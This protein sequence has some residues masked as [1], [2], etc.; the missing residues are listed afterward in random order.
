MPEP[1]SLE[2]SHLS[3]VPVNPEA[4]P[5]CDHSTLRPFDSDAGPLPP[6]PPGQPPPLGLE[7][8]AD[9]F[10]AGPPA[11]PG[12][13]ILEVLGRGGMGVVYKARHLAL[14]RLVALKVILGGPHASAAEVVRFRREAEAVARL[15]NPHIVQIHEVGE[16]N[17]LPYF[18]LEYCSGGSLADKT[19]GT[20]LPAQQAAQLLQTL[21]R[22]VHAAHQG[23][24]IHRDLKPANILLQR[25][26]EIPN[27]KSEN[28]GGALV[29]DIGFRIS[30]FDP[31]ITDFGLAKRLDDS[32]GQTATGAIV[33]TP[34]Y[35][36]PEQAMG[37]REA[38]GAGVDV[39]ALGAV[40]YELL[41]GRPPFN[42]ETPL[43]TVRQV[44]EEE[45]VSPRLLQPKTPRDLETVCLKCLAKQPARRYATAEALADDLARFL[46]DEPIAARPVG[47]LERAW[48]WAKRRPLAAA[49]A[50]VSTAAVLTLLGVG[51]WYNARLREAVREEQA[52]TAHARRQQKL[53]ET[54]R[55][56]AEANLLDARRAVDQMLTEVAQ[57]QLARVPQMEPVR[58]ALLQKALA[59]YQRFLRQTGDD[60]GVRLE[61]GRA[62]RR[63]ADIY[64]LL[65]QRR[66]AEASYGQAL[67]LLGRLADNYAREPR[68]RFELAKTQRRHGVLLRTADRRTQA[69]I[70][71]RQ[72]RVVLE[73]LVDNHPDQPGYLTELATVHNNLGNLLKDEHQLAQAEKAYRMALAIQKKLVKQ[74]RAA[75]RYQADL[76]MTYNN[77]AI[78]LRYTRRLSEAGKKYR[79]AI[80]ILEGLVRDHPKEPDYRLG[81]AKSY[82]N[83]FNLLHQLKRLKEAEEICRQMVPLCQQLADEFPLVPQ[84]RD[85]L[86]N[87]HN[88][89][90]VLLTY[91]NRAREAE[92]PLRS[93]LEIWRKLAAAYPKVSLYKGQMGGALS[94]L[95]EALT[96]QG[97]LVE[98]RRLVEEAIGHQQAAHKLSPKQLGYLR[99]LRNHYWVLAEITVK[100]G[101]HA[102]VF[103]AARKAV[104]V[105]DNDAAAHCRAAGLVARCIALAEKDSQLDAA[106]RKERAADYRSRALR[107]LRDGLRKGYKDFAK[108]EKDK[109]YTAL[110]ACDGFRE[111]LTQARPK[112]RPGGK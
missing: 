66:E 100:Q 71:Y 10:A 85:L 101:D 50:G 82:N 21:A 28:K 65:G 36:A 40:L 97:K 72:A 69:A 12:Y 23:G 14:N 103:R 99:F 7:I 95:A 59:F 108:I 25:Q 15:Q 34:S 8:A 39:Y 98:A 41:T 107:W 24:I 18:S 60:P 44:V 46:R 19:N 38:I 79:S 26:S 73:R 80:D 37:K 48:R 61:T 52:S 33:G 56:R 6:P 13:E 75:V 76:V 5:S 68:Y 54:Q 102:T 88:V 94:N 109:D 47:Q 86:G 17:G 30:D 83:L 57:S 84:Y 22:A 35:M 81:L 32:A 1:H 31:K 89:L 29:S 110:R 112:I 49:L 74:F 64:V 87:S 11:L 43:D 91:T 93:A 92:K 106:R 20:P 96:Y 67:A 77:L 2:P 27:P 70:A 105:F 111:V 16:H 78:V 55:Q 45:P 3:Q 4:L 62:H 51:L 42:A 104:A 9:A 90:G 58:R 53:A 63:V